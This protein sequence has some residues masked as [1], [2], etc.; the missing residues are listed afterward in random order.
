MILNK[1]ELIR[2]LCRPVEDDAGLVV[3]PLLCPRKAFDADAIDLRLGTNFIL[4]RSDR[5]AVNVPGLAEGD[6]FQRP[7]HV[8]LGG[9]LVLPGHH[10]V[11]A[12]TLE[13]IKVPPDIAAMILT[14]SS[15]ARTFISVETA[16]WV[17]P[18]YRGCL[19]LEIAN[20]SETPIV[21]HPGRRVAQI[22]FLHVSQERGDC[23]QDKLSGNYI[24]PVR[25]EA[26]A[27]AEPK[28][29]LGEELGLDAGE[30]QMPG[31]DTP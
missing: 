1:T 25:P 26:P 22:V 27:L 4:S 18:C 7:V 24:G 5:L 31:D 11:L 2:R 12:S 29:V 16:P 6:K 9:Y 28:E 3:T 23:P 14:K 20:V 30:V 8:P 13:Y 10:T 17:H 15:W 21:I 19:T